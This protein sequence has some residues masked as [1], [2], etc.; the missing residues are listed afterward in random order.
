MS[1]LLRL[2][3]DSAW[4]HYAQAEIHES[5]LQ[6][7]LA[8][9]EYRK[10]LEKSPGM[11]GIH[12]RIGRCRLAKS[13][14][15]ESLDAAL[16]EFQAELQVAPSNAEAEYEIGE[17]YRERNKFDVALEHFTRA[18]QFH[19]AFFEAQIGLA[20]S[21]ISL[22]RQR[23]ALLH[24]QGAVQLD[25]KNEIPHYLLA[26]IYRAL[27]DSAAQQKE[28]AIFQKL[29]AAASVAVPS[30]RGPASSQV[31]EQKLDQ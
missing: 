30:V 22:G 14:A 16:Q 11:P 12:Y 13:R 20:R 19:Q 8:I 26:S 21:L 17:I 15:P 10:V 1:R 2:D 31:S 29:H 28:M 23:E 24:L 27:G 25:P 7:D 6:Y 4:V 5:S 9:A 18:T 3:P